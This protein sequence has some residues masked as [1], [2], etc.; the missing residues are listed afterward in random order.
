MHA[1]NTQHSDQAQHHTSERE[2]ER[3]R[4]REREREREK[5][6]ERCMVTLAPAGGAKEAITD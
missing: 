4:A 3:E 6:R 1:S 5:E 2:R